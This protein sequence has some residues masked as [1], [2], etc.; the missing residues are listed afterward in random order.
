MH[1][2]A[3]CNT[4]QGKRCICDS[5]YV[6]LNGHMNIWVLSVMDGEYGYYMP[7]YMT[8]HYLFKVTKG[9]IVSKPVVAERSN[10]GRK[11]DPDTRANSLTENRSSSSSREHF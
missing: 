11:V 9:V 7:T 3:Y 1:Y 8:A 5:F 4:L 2:D 10:R 6:T